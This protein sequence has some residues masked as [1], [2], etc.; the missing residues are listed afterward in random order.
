[1]A[2]RSRPK[3]SPSVR[4][5]ARQS[6]KK[7]LVNKMV[8]SKLKTLAKKVSEAVTSNN[9]EQAQKTLIEAVRAYAHAASKGVIH[10]NNSARNISRLTL[11][12][13]KLAKAQAA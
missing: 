10:K 6:V 8:K 13:N 7:Q 12:V 9:A 2:A 5:R 4:K 11:K 1:M 3:K